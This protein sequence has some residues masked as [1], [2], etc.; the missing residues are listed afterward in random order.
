M[1]EI[2]T[3]RQRLDTYVGSFFVIH[4]QIVAKPQASNGS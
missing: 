1:I 2:G 3:F 4:R